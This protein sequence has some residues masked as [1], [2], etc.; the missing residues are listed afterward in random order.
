M[1]WLGLSFFLVARMLGER[2]KD[3]GLEVSDEDSSKSL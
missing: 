3:A 2:S 1:T